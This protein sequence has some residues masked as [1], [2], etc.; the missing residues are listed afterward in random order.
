[1]VLSNVDREGFDATKAGPLDGVWFD[2]IIT[3][4]EVGSYYKPDRRSFG[5]MLETV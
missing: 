1:M 4:Q 3:A 2:G 5:Y